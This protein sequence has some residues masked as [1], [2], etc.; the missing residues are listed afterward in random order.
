MRDGGVVL[1]EESEDERRRPGR[2]VVYLVQAE[3]TKD[4]G[5]DERGEE[6]GVW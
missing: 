1:G 2:E 6:S 5:E 4:E 3:G